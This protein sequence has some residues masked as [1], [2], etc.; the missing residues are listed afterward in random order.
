M[1]GG[2]GGSWK[3][4]EYVE[5]GGQKTTNSTKISLKIVKNHLFQIYMT[6]IVDTEKYLDFCKRSY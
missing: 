3:E 4:V 2:V 6:N 1:D 5:V